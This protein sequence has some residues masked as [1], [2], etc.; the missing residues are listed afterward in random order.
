ME[1]IPAIGKIFLSRTRGLT[2]PRKLALVYASIPPPMIMQNLLTCFVNNFSSAGA[3]RPRRSWRSLGLLVVLALAASGSSAYA[4]TRN[5]IIS[6][7]ASVAAGSKV[8]VTVGAS[9]D[10]GGGEHV[11]FLHADYS[12]DGGATWTAISYAT[13]AG[14]KV[15]FKATITAG[16]GGSKV[17]VR[18]R[19][20]YRGGK[21]GDVDYTGKPI[22]WTGS[23]DNWQEP[24]AK[25]ATIAVVAK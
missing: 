12:V 1:N 10:A 7:P 6:A 16:A 11:G 3:S 24:P 19:V 17:L 22:A 18:I 4:V 15:S 23:W 5:I 21:D 2:A 25:T 8:N 14:V 20:A 9:T 13:K